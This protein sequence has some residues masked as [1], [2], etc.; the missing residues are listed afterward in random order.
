MQAWNQ[1]KVTNQDS[2]FKDEAG[3]VVRVETKGKKELVTVALDNF[4]EDVQTFDATELQ[5]LC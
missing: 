1:V 2:Q 4:P 5:I 3:V